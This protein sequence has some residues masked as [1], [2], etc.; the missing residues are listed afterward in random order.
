[1]L[2]PEEPGVIGIRKM[3]HIGENLK[4]VLK[5]NREA[6]LVTDDPD[7]LAD[8][9]EYLACMDPGARFTPQ[10]KRGLWDGYIHFISKQGK[11]PIG[12]AHKVARHLV[13]DMGCDVKMVDLRGD[14]LIPDEVPDQIGYKVLYDHQVKAVQSVFERKLLGVP[15]PRGIIQSATNSGKSVMGMAIIKALYPTVQCLVLVHRLEILEQWYTWLVEDMDTGIGRITPK[16]SLDLP[17]TVAMIPT[18]HSRWKTNRQW[19]S[20]F[21]KQYD[22][23][24]VDEAHHASSDTWANVIFQSPAYFKIALS[25]TA[26]VLEE[27]RNTRLRG[28]FGPVLVRITNK[29]MVDAE[30]SAK[31]DIRFVKYKSRPLVEVST[32]V[33]GL[34]DE[35]ISARQVLRMLEKAKRPTYQADR[36]LRDLQRKLYQAVHFRGICMS[37][38]RT[39]AVIDIVKKHPNETILIVVSKVEKHGFRLVNSLIE[40]GEDAVFVSGKSKPDVRKKIYH[41]FVNGNIRRLVATMIYKEGVD[42]PAIDVL[43]MAMGEKAPVT[44]LQT[45]GRSL[46]KR[47]DKSSVPVYD[48]F[49]TSHPKLEEHSSDRMLIYRKEGFNPKFIESN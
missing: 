6:K 32:Q 12:L 10:F 28:L 25:G 22:C 45:F 36:K 44:V 46:R 49:D 24:I 42:V 14:R 18:L 39:Q 34:H 33:A 41:D 20:D 38:Y 4:I 21:I 17:I 35:V 43:I 5:N 40:S 19:F 31:P 23:L 37:K 1:M 27:H 26:T 48:F 30:V 29:D 3:S 8:V 15:F 11:F 9:D 13:K 2:Q 47:P 7:I 16:E